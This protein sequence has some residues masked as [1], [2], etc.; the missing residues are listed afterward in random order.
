[1]Y[2]LRPYLGVV[3]EEEYGG[4]IEFAFKPMN[5]VT[6]LALQH[7]A[8]LILIVQTCGDKYGHRIRFTVRCG[9]RVRQADSTS[10][11]LHGPSTQLLMF[12]AYG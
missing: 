11:A 5:K 9:S 4:S 1:M 12:L 2:L 8:V 7:A 10:A 3:D 6:T